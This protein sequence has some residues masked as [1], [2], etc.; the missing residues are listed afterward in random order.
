MSWTENHAAKRGYSPL[1][2]VSTLTA[3]F[4]RL[5]APNNIVLSTRKGVCASKDNFS[6]AESAVVRETTDQL[7]SG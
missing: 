6:E 1:R 4:D 2:L 7:S 5:G 3:E